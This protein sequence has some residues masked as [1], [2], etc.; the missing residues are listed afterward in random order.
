[1]DSLAIG[2]VF[3]VL[4]LL[5]FRQAMARGLSLSETERNAAA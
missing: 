4:L 5:A 2:F 1:M 3:A